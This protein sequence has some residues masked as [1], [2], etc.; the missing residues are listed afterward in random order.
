MTEKTPPN[1]R[2]FSVKTRFQELAQRP[3]GLPRDVAIQ[4]AEAQMPDCAPSSSTGSIAN[5]RIS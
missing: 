2:I 3:G 5:C 4:Q 1:V